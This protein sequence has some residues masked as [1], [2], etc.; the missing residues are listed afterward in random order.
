VAGEK[1][2]HLG[3][4]RLREQRTRTLT[5][6]VGERISERPWLGKLE[7]GSLGHGV[8]LV[9]DDFCQRY[10]SGFLAP[11]VGSCLRLSADRSSQTKRRLQPSGSWKQNG[12][13]GARHSAQIIA[14]HT[15]IR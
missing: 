5:Q 14:P 3:L 6:N 10:F 13:R 15:C 12:P 8:S 7:N 9:W 4:D 1:I 2:R 11:M